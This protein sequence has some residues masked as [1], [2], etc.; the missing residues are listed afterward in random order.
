MATFQG[1]ICTIKCSYFGTFHSGLNTGVATFQVFRLEGVHCIGL[2]Y[3][4]IAVICNSIGFF[5]VN[6]QCLFAAVKGWWPK[7]C[8]SINFDKVGYQLTIHKEPTT[9]LTIYVSLCCLHITLECMSSHSA[10][11]INN[12]S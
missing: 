12:T 3:K 8:D 7:Q 6:M 9:K 10:I 5:L 2:C 11:K 1:S 4:L